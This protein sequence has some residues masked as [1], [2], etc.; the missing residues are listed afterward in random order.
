MTSRRTFLE[1]AGGALLGIAGAPAVLAARRQRP[2]LVIR[3]GTVF[4]GSG[5]PGVEADVAV[6]GGRVARIAPRIAGAGALEI[7]AR[8][9]AVA[10]GFVDLH[11]HG[12]GSLFADPLAE[13]VVRQGVTTIVVGQDG[14]ARRRRSAPAARRSASGSPRSTSSAPR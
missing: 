4:D 5:A 11:S 14:R 1:V 3:G 6:A 2:D 10:P 8:G 12:D 9:R 13:S 7:D